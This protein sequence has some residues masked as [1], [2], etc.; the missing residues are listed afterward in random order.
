MQTERLLLLLLLRYGEHT[1]F[2]GFTILWQDQNTAGPQ[3]APEGL[4]VP[5]GG[6]QVQMPDGFW[7][8]RP[9]LPGAFTVNAGDLIQV[10]TNDVLLSNS[11]RVV[12]PPPGDKSDRISIVFFTGPQNDSVI[13]CLPTCFSPDRPPRY[14]P[15]QAGEHFAKKLAATN[16]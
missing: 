10:W 16:M 14:S 1:D 7:A 8:D 4:Q 12:N 9:P 5:P 3:M 13:D 11:H 2:T 15:I 6:L